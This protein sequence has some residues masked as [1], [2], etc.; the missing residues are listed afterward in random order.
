MR[1]ADSLGITPF[2]FA[3]AVATLLLLTVMV[4][5]AEAARGDDPDWPCPQ[6]LVPTVMAGAYWTDLPSDAVGDWRADPTV[7]DL[8]RRIT[9]RRVSEQEGKDAIARFAEPLTADA[10][11]RL[12]PMAFAGVLEETNA[13]RTELIRHIKRFTRRQLDLT[14]LVAR[15]TAEL[16]SVPDAAPNAEELRA[17]LEQRRFFTTKAFQDAERTL[18]YACE[19]PVELEAR[20]GA[21]ARALRAAWPK[22]R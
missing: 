6:R 12:L 20:L 1:A 11:R 9:P 4:R 7:A 17:E 8:V 14:D 5:P 16:H 15:I 13:Q 19:A 10:R 18:R 22:D 3:R 2:R 21:Y